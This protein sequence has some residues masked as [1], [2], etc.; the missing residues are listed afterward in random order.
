MVQGKQPAQTQKTPEIFKPPQT[1]P[2]RTSGAEGPNIQQEQLAVMQETIKLVKW[3]MSLLEKLETRPLVEQLHNQEA[4]ISK[5]MQE[6][7]EY[8][9]KNRGLIAGAGEDCSMV[10]AKLAELWVDAPTIRADTT[11]ATQAD[12]E[13]WLRSQRTSNKELA[14]LIEGQMRVLAGIEEFRI[15]MD[16]AK[17]KVES[18]LAV[19]RLKT[20]QI[21]FLG[22]SI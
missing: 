5:I 19:L 2:P 17:R 12:K 10:K 15:N 13:A 21:E 16:I 14:T 3:K 6:E 22:R 20:A 1:Q 11:K 7:L 9:N 4:E 18:T 8:K